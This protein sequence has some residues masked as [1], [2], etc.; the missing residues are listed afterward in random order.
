ML[1]TTI[2][3]R[4]SIIA[5]LMI[6]L[7]SGDI[8]SQPTA[9][10]HPL[11][12]IQ[13]PTNVSGQIN[14]IGRVC[15]MKF[16]PSDPQKVY[17]VSASGGLWISQNG[18]QSWQKCGTDGL[19]L[20]ACASVCVDFTNDSILYLGTGDPNYYSTG[21]GLYK[22]TDAGTT[23]TPSNTGM[24]TLMA[25]ELL[26]DPLDHLSIVAATNNGIYK[27]NDGG[28]TWVVKLSG[29]QFTDMAMKPAGNTRTLYAVNFSSL[30]KSEDFGETWTLISNGISVPGGGSGQGLRLAVSAADSNVVYVGMIKDEGTIFRSNDGGNSFTMVYHNPSQSLVGYD[31]NGNGQGN[32]NFTMVA[33][34]TN[35][36][37]VYTGAHVVWKSTDGGQTWNQLTQWWAVLHTDMHDFVIN[38][39]NPTEIYN[40]NDG[41]VWR[42][43]NG[44]NSW[45]PRSNGIEATEIYKAASDP[46]RKELISIGTQD[47]GELYSFGG[48]WKTNRGG[49]WTSRAIFDYSNQ[50]RVYY[51]ENGMRRQLNISSAETDFGITFSPS[52]SM[53]LSFTPLNTDYAMAALYGD[54]YLTTNLNDP[55]PIWGQMNTFSGGIRAMEFSSHWDQKIYVLEAPN[56]FWIGEDL[57]IWSPTLT[58]YTLPFG[59]GTNSGV[60]SM[61]ADTN[62]L[63]IYSGSKVYRSSDQGQTWVNETYNLPSI[64]LL[65]VFLDPYSTDE[66]LYACNAF[67]VWYKNKFST[68]WIG[69]N[70]GFPSIANITE[71]M[72]VDDGPDSSVIRVATYGRGVWE[73]FVASAFTG[74]HSPEVPQAEILPNPA[75][76]QITVKMPMLAGTEIAILSADGKT[77]YTGKVAAQSAGTTLDIQDLAPG[78]YVVQFTAD[79]QLTGRATFVKQ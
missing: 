31:A 35:A 41:G 3:F 75:H 47:N 7:T 9:A 42:S 76:D 28:A 68:S 74:I 55:T 56:K 23:W 78:I 6:V 8:F 30:Y 64:N 43:I 44:G 18:T 48:I 5:V 10:W 70:Q 69:Y 25:V 53:K 2:N 22:S 34:P 39:Y 77:V 79:K 65:K 1:K 17:A 27:T 51:Y 49:D 14:G 63:Y 45:L 24:G 50:N 67:G 21:L 62:I 20:T 52:N 58:Q 54:L 4:N 16:H 61:A 38:P 33:D 12:P 36:N 46:M 72:F 66:S 40:I 73:T 37:I 26:M 11:G 32:Y 29:G 57:S 13:F 19:A 60:I 71:F 59:L 15:Q